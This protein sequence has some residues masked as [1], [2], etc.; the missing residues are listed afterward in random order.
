MDEAA[1]PDLVVEMIYRSDD[2]I[3]LAVGEVTAVRANDIAIAVTAM[4]DVVIRMRYRSPEGATAVDRGAKRIY[5]SRTLGRT[6]RDLALVFRRPLE[7]QR[8]RAI[9]WEFFKL[10]SPFPSTPNPVTAAMNGC[11]LIVAAVFPANGWLIDL[12]Q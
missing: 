5:T 1:Y 7:A 4:N 2:Q 8:R 10:V 6:A 9:R 12:W 3:G 11:N